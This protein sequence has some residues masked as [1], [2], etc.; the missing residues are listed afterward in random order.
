MSRRGAVAVLIVALPLAACD[1]RDAAPDPP[2]A[3]ASTVSFEEVA[4]ERGLAFRMHFLPTEQGEKFKVNLYDHGSGVAVA[5]IDG[6]RDDDVLLL[7]QL[8]PNGLFRNDGSGRFADVTLGSG[9]EL[10]GRICVAAVF[11]DYDSD[12]DQDLYVTTTRGGNALLRNDGTGGFEDVTAAAGLTLVAHSMQ[13]VFFDADQDGDLDLFVSQTAQWTY[14][15][16]DPEGRY[17]LGREQL[18]DLMDSPPETNRYYR[19]EGDGRFTD[20]TADAGVAGAGWGS[21]VAVFD[22]DDD[23]DLDLFVANMFGA[24]LLF[25]NEGGGRFVEVGA[26]VLRRGSWGA[27]GAKVFDHDVDGRLD[28]L[29][30]DMHSDM[31]AQP[32]TPL[33]R[34]RPD[35]K[36]PTPM[37][38]SG[39]PDTIASGRSLV[40]ALQV[41]FDRALFGNA[42]YRAKG[43]GAFEEVSDKA[44]V[45]TFWPWGAAAGD[46]D[47]DGAEDLYLPSGMGFPFPYWPSPLLVNRGD[48][49][50]VDRSREA[51][52]EPLPDGQHLPDRIGGR[53]AARSQRAAATADFDGD[54]RLD[55]VVNT[56]N[57]RALLFANRS[58]A[59]HWL[60]FRLTA[61]R[62]HRDAIGALVTVRAGGRT[63]VRQVQTAGGYLAQ[64]SRTLHFGLGDATKLEACEIRWPNGERQS[65]E[66]AAID[67]VHD[68]TEPSQVR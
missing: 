3:G 13:P 31:W 32:N 15:E 27:V 20:A 37:G 29:V 48:G 12:G 19:N 34:V 51:G 36:Y 9:V 44:G 64:S 22:F 43:A 16:L 38:P 46:F 8:G 25:R 24:S 66:I 41:D 35:R 11:G 2:A 5:D 67:R 14:D 56:F 4:R 45:E 52:V 21:D 33:S 60:G 6:D 59:R 49:R 28:L 54:G 40:D 62:S 50:F 17:H 30:V 10:P 18:F 39:N 61:T 63:Q 57:D 58:P 7:D 42:L 55:I 68:V 23:A 26:K 65:L 1:G 47:R 53:E